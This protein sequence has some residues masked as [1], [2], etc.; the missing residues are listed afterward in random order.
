MAT[1]APTPWYK[2]RQ[3]LG[4]AAAVLVVGAIGAGVL[5]GHASKRAESPAP[6]SDTIQIKV[7]WSAEGR[8]GDQIKRSFV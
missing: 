7:R 5:G 8:R 3:V 4:L 2:K 1:P 6:E